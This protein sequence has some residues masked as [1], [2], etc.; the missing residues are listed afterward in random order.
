M[1]T[2]LRFLSTVQSATA[3]QQI[4]WCWSVILLPGRGSSDQHTSE[5]GAGAKA[6][7]QNSG[8][9]AGGGGGASKQTLRHPLSQSELS[10]CPAS[11]KRELRALFHKLVETLGGLLVP[12]ALAV[13][14][15]TSCSGRIGS[16]QWDHQ[17]AVVVLYALNVPFDH[18]DFGFVQVRRPLSFFIATSALN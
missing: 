4:V 13:T 1:D 9:A 12:P 5:G 6:A 14:G 3:L 2:V 10:G 17:L 11:L 15:S 8:D 16:T 18:E 7:K